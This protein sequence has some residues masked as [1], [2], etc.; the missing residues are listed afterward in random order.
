LI[1]FTYKDYKRPVAGKLQLIVKALPVVHPLGTQLSVNFVE[2][3]PEGF[4]VRVTN[5]NG[6]QLKLEELQRAEL[7]VEVSEYGI[8]G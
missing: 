5:T 8:A 6:T 1:T 2:F 4:A 3:R 7:M